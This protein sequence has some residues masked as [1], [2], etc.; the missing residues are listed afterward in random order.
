MS[1]WLRLEFSRTTWWRL[2]R[3]LRRRGGGRRESGAFLLGRRTSGVASIRDFVC[4]DDLD[5]RALK[6]GC[7]TFHGSGFPRLW[8]ICRERDLQV[9]ADVHTHPG[10]D[11]RQSGIDQRHPMIPVAGHI[12]LIVPQ[13]ATGNRFSLRGVGVHEYRGGNWKDR[14]GEQPAAVRLTWSS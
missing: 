6:S 12:A 5:P 4:Y 10:R 14:T 9:I 3:E 13:F 8:E 11:T 1:I 2:L 7:V